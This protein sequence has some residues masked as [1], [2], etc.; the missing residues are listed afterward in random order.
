MPN[1]ADATN[2]IHNGWMAVIFALLAMIVNFSALM[3]SHLSA[4]RI[5]SNMR[6][7]LLQ[8]ITKMPIGKLDEIGTG[9]LRK[10]VSE[11][12]GATETY[13]AHQL[14]DMSVAIATPICMI[15]LLFIF[16]LETRFSK[17]NSNNFRIYGNV[18]NGWKSNAR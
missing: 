12:I 18:K 14:P 2:M 8:H 11:A 1:F 7:K 6:I 15:V 13:L 5:A 16:R 4:F 17:F 3:C 10:I 9:K